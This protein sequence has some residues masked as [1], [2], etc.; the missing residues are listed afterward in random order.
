MSILHYFKKSSSC[1]K[2][3]LP[4]PTGPLSEKVLSKVIV[5]ANQKVTNTGKLLKS[6]RRPYLTLTP[7]QKLRVGR[8]AME[9]GTTTAI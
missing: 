2:D 9:N 8:R 7:E 6:I 5:T 1:T 3:S 4:D